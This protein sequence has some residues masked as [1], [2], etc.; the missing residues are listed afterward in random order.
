VLARLLECSTYGGQAEWRSVRDPR[1]AAFLD[2][3][4][5]EVMEASTQGDAAVFDVSSGELV[6][7]RVAYGE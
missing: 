5:A 6:L 2:A 1:R 7:L 4:G 3:T